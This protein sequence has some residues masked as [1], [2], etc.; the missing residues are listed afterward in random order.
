MEKAAGAVPLFAGY[1][2]RGLG[3]SRAWTR[4]FPNEAGAQI[5]VRIEL[6][7]VGSILSPTP[8]YVGGMHVMDEFWVIPDIHYCRGCF[9][10]ERVER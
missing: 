4:L 2:S 8:T 6:L 10:G 1:R 7:H 3:C 5:A 9:Y